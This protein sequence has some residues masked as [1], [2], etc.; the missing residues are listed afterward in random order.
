MGVV[1][2]LT[3]Q[4]HTAC[5]PPNLCPAS[6]AAQWSPEAIRLENLLSWDREMGSVALEG[7]RRRAQKQGSV[8]PVPSFVNWARFCRQQDVTWLMCG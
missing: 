8:T 4:A 1:W 3:E 2:P 6:R 7:R 5:F